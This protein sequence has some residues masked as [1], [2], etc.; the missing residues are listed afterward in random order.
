LRAEDDGDGQQHGRDGPDDRVENNIEADDEARGRKRDAHAGREF[1]VP[2]VGVVRDAV[3]AGADPLDEQDPKRDG[4]GEAK[5][6]QP[7][8]CRLGYWPET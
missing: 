7:K 2:E 4:Q 8:G 1:G 5:D 3:G 6:T